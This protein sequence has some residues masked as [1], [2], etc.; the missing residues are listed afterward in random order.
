MFDLNNYSEDSKF[1]DPINEK[2]VCKMKDVH[3]RN[4]INKLI[5][6]KLKIHCLFLDNCQ[7]FKTAKGVNRIWV[8]RQLS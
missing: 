1:F 5:G 4:W 2:V 7:Q 8:K 6:L 3:K